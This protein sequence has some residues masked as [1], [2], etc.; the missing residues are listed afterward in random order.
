MHTVN[1]KT[2]RYQSQREQTFKWGPFSRMEDSPSKLSVAELAGRFKGHIVPMSNA[3]D[4]SP[5]RRKPPCSLRFPVRE[6]DVQE[7]DTDVVSTSPI[8]IRMKSSNIIARLQANLALSP[9]T[10]LPSPKGAELNREPDSPP[11]P[12]AVETT[13]T[14]LNPTLR[15]ARLSVE[16]EEQEE[17]AGFNSPP[18]GA[19]LPNFHKT[20]V[21]LS[22]KRR[23]PTR[24]HRRSAGE[25]AS[26]LQSPGECTSVEA[27]GDGVL[28]CPDRVTLEE[29][30]GEEDERRDS[31]EKQGARAKTPPEDEEETRGEEEARR[32]QQMDGGDAR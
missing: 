30:E 17:P 13:V 25:E 2:S 23:P 32:P 12:A 4:E 31:Q 8:K 28:Q 19:T 24:Q 16:E 5:F 20:R 9:T 10:L 3:H 29:G 7:S 26:L 21:R 18:E 27:N 11:P 1:Y 15:S 22:F 14:P 6:D